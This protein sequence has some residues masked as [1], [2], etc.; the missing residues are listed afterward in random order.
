MAR[1]KF[2]TFER[3][4]RPATTKRMG[5]LAAQYFRIEANAIHPRRMRQPRSKHHVEKPPYRPWL[6][7]SNERDAGERAPEMR[8]VVDAP[9]VLLRLPVGVGQIAHRKQRCR[10]RNR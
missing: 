4:L 1:E 8:V 7:R 5:G 6:R 9:S 2:S 10:D 3:P